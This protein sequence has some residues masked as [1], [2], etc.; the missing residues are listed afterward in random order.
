MNASANNEHII[1][2]PN[3]FAL[4][5]CLVCWF[6]PNKVWQQR[7]TLGK[8]CHKQIWNSHVTSNMLFPVKQWSRQSLAAILQ[9]WQYWASAWGRGDAI[10]QGLMFSTSH[11]SWVRRHLSIRHL[12]IHHLRAGTRRE[13]TRGEAVLAG[14]TYNAPS[15][16]PHRAFDKK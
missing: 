3:S 1:E 5:C 14:G 2:I 12:S 8:S 13:R 6:K 15:Q 7:K 10:G 9:P 16:P 4:I 11:P